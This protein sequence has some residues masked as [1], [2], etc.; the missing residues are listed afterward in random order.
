[1][2][3]CR[4]IYWEEINKLMKKL[5][6]KIEKSGY[7]PD[8]IVAV[9]RGGYVPARILCDMLNVPDLVSIQVKKWKTISKLKEARVKYSFKAEVEGKKVLLVDDVADTGES[10]IAARDHILKMG[11]VHDLRTAVIHYKSRTSKIVP[12]Y[13]A[14][15]IKEWIWLI[16]PWDY[17]ENLID[18]IEYVLNDKGELC[19]EEISKE[20]EERYNIILS[21]SD[22]EEVVARGAS[23]GFFEYRN[24]IVRLKKR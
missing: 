23:L 20:L 17:Y 3:R 7:K 13:Y 12:D 2:V 14:E 10:L 6:E 16:Y 24:G 22:I 8:V 15:E 4:I 11:N 1:M 19:L 21:V 5:A 18:L 9:A